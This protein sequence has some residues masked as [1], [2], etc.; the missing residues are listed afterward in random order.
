MSGRRFAAVLVLSLTLGL[1]ACG[2]TPMYGA[3][4]AAR[5]LEDVRI[6]TGEERIDFLLQEALLDTMGARAA[7]GPLTLR[8]QSTTNVLGLG[9]GAEAI[10]VRYAVQLRV[11]YEVVN[12]GSGNVVFAGQVS[13]EASYNASNEAYATQAARLDAEERAAGEVAE[14]ITMQLARAARNSELW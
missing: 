12:S 6:E 5:G 8:T 9:I 7:T 11:S 4:S 2:F 1:S 14:R 13:T 10:A 3:G